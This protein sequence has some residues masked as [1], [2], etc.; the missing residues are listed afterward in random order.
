MVLNRIVKLIS[1]QLKQIIREKLLILEK[2][3]LKVTQQEQ[4]WQHDEKPQAR[5]IFFLGWGLEFSTE[6]RRN[7]FGT[8]EYVITMFS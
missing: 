6:D 1:I 4:Q 2:I 8:K 7:K 3:C 5:V